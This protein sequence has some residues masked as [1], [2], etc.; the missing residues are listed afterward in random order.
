MALANLTQ[1]RSHLSLTAANSSL[2]TTLQ[3][4]LDESCASVV[5]RLSRDIEASNYTEYLS[6]NGQKDLVLKQ[7]PVNTA[8]ATIAVY[9][10]QLGA[11]GAGNNSFNATTSLLN[12]GTDCVVIPDGPNTSNSGVLRRLGSTFGTAFIGGHPAGA[13]STPY[14]YAVWPVGDGNIKVTYTGG[15]ANVPADIQSGVLQLAATVYR[16]RLYGGLFQA[17]E[18]LGE[19]RTTLVALMQQPN[20][21]QPGGV[22]YFL[23]PYLTYAV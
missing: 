22:A 14:R 20:A 16:T 12:Y 4:I 11:Y 5:S 23:R 8:A 17:A 13:L 3:Q 2:N 21:M 7:R 10:D 19:Y 9:Q 18:S 15:F 1:L 6:G